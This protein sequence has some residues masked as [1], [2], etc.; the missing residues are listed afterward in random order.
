MNSGAPFAAQLASLRAE[1]PVQALTLDAGTIRYIIGGRGPETILVLPAATGRAE[2]SLFLIGE[3][4]KFARVVAI[5]YPPVSTMR[6]LVQTI[7][8]AL[9]HLNVADVHVFGGSYGGLVAQC[10]VREHPE[11]AKSL[12]LSHSGIADRRRVRA[13]KVVLPLLRA[14]PFGLV[15][16]MMFAK[17]RRLLRGTS[18]PEFWMQFLKDEFAQLTKAELFAAFARVHDLHQN[19]SFV[20]EN[21]PDVPTLILESAQEE[22]VAPAERAAM[23]AAYPGAQVYTFADA[24]H[25]VA[26]T[27]REE[28][29]RVIVGFIQSSRSAAT[30]R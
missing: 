27:H 19:Y 13:F 28:Y 26:I 14:L 23:K 7:C 15:R 24:G 17:F 21:A 11:L 1:F 3:F 10:L 25:A 29:V 4:A 22:M 9:R 30:V 6:E 20:P 2:S 8:A 12:V 5:S 18:H 16:W